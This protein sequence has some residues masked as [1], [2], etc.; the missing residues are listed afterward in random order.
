M[1]NST[2]NLINFIN[3]SPSAYHCIERV[4]SML[5][6][7]DVLDASRPFKIKAGGK[8]AV[9]RGSSALI[10]FSLPEDISDVSF[11]IAAAHVDS[12]ALKLKPECDS[13]SA[14]NV[15]RV[16]IEKYGGANL[17]SWYDRVLTVAGRICVSEGEKIISKNVYVDSDLMI[18]PSVPA[19]LG[20]IEKPSLAVDFLP[21]YAEAGEKD[22]MDVVATAAGV[23]KEDILSHDLFAVPRETGKIF[24]A[25]GEFFAS[26]R[27]DDL[28]CVYA[29]TEAISK[30]RPSGISVL[31]LFNNEE[32]GSSSREGAFS[33]F[34]PETLERI[35]IALGKDRGDFQAS[36]ASSFMVSADNAHA[37]HPA[38]PEL[39]DSLNA[40]VMNGGIV[41]KTNASQRY[42]TDA[43]SGAIV[44]KL[45]E[46]ADV[47][48]QSYANR[49]DIAGGSTLGNIALH[50]LPVC[51]ADIGLAQLAMHSICE[52]A[53]SK[54]TSYLIKFAKVLFESKFS[55]LG[56][57]GYEIR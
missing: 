1:N 57:N 26:P 49:A 48:Y 9:T 37:K 3:A 55:A 52:S 50:Q 44:K 19:H 5:E 54:D 41:I 6:G 17:A 56:D 16:A 25:N 34:L 53:G 43:V 42:T 51:C 40:P 22:I 30:A 38:H 24:G 29:L 12:P 47:P 21:L 18:I 33:T 27:I 15:R 39:F 36:L 2:K 46:K 13:A 31:A 20:T 32:T 10:A 8:Y 14:G 4:L 35:V 11:S 45:C 23:N 7:F 28:Q